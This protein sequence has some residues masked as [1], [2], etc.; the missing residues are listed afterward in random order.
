MHCPLATKLRSQLGDEAANM[1]AEGSNELEQGGL[2]S[3]DEDQARNEASSRRSKL[4]LTRESENTKRDR[5]DEGTMDSQEAKC[6]KTN[7][8]FQ[9]KVLKEKVEFVMTLFRNKGGQ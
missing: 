3:P 7:G 5:P 2:K 1:A 4:R 6:R 9:H 8:T